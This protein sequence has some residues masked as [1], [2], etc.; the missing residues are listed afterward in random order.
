L[1]VALA[2]FVL[3]VVLALFDDVQAFR[4]SAAAS[5][6]EKVKALN[7]ILVLGIVF[8][9]LDTPEGC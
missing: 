5:A 1:V 2:L 8:L 3:P 6:D 7:S 4:K 9:L